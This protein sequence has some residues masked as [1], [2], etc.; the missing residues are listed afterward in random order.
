MNYY[1]DFYEGLNDTRSILYKQI[2]SVATL[3]KLL[4]TICC[5][6]HNLDNYKTNVVGENSYIYKKYLDSLMLK[7][8]RFDKKLKELIKIFICHK[9]FYKNHWK[10]KVGR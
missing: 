2:D 1:D 8:K 9:N 4:S 5:E 10:W 7:M 3:N 6:I